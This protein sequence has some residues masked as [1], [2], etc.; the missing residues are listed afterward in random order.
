MKD[1]MKE[2]W[3][4]QRLNAPSPMRVEGREVDNPFSFG[5]LQNGGLSDEATNLLRGVW[6][7]DYMGAAEFE[8]G[9]VPKALRK[10]A[11]A[12]LTAFDVTIPREQIA[13][14]WRGDKAATEGVVYVL[15]PVD[16]KPQVCER[17]VEFAK[18]EVRLKEPTRLPDALR[19]DEDRRLPQGWLELDNGFLFFTDPEMWVKAA[20]LFGVNVEAAEIKNREETVK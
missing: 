8:F 16:F 1:E 13:D 2:S 20:L 10:I 11:G 5:G 12:K 14:G 15:C 19:G 17:I 6:S 18:D 4:V 9:A 3:L 7:F